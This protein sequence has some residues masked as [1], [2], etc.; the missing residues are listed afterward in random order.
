MNGMPILL[1]DPDEAQAVR[2][3][4]V[5][6][7]GTTDERFTEV[8]E[9]VEVVPPLPNDDHQ[10]VVMGV[11]AALYNAIQVPGLGKVRP[12]VNVGDRV[13]G[14]THN[15]RGPDVVAYLT[16]NPA[17]N[18]GEFWHGGP[19]LLVEVL[20]RGEDPYAKFDFYAKVNTREMLLVF[21]ET[22][23][24]ELHRL[25]SGRLVPAGRSDVTTPAAVPS[26]VLPL[27]FRLKS[28]AT[29]PVIEV[30]HTATGQVWTA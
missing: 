13:A 27:T 25:E 15:Y 16:A 20:S 2:A 14:W 30:T 21:H 23:Y 28:A 10:D 8:W 12:G 29:R 22:W 18:H 26:A 19:D 5:T 4:Y 9:G 3:E 1:L 17:V 6:N 24:L 7:G 11:S